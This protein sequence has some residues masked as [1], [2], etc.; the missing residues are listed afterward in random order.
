MP[1]VIVLGPSGSSPGVSTAE[2]PSTQSATL[3]A[4]NPTTPDSESPYIR[5]QGGASEQIALVDVDR[6]VD[7]GDGAE[8]LTSHLHIFKGAAWP[9]GTHTLTISPAIAAWDA[10]TVTYDS[11]PATGTPTIDVVVPAA[12]SAGD[13]LIVDVTDILGLSVSEADT[14]WYGFVLELD[15]TSE[16]TLYSAFAEPDFRPYVSVEEGYPLEEPAD[17]QPSDG[18]VVSQLKPGFT[19]SVNDPRGNEFVTG[20]HFQL[21]T[22]EDFE[23][24]TYDSGEV[25]HDEAYFDGA[26]P[27]GGAAAFSDLTPGTTYY[28]RA[29]VRNTS[30][31]WSGWSDPAEFSVEEKGTL[32]ID[33]PTITAGE[34][35][36]PVPTI[37]VTF[38]PANAESLETLGVEVEV[39]KGNVWDIHYEVPEHIN[40][41]TDFTIPDSD[42]LPY[43]KTLRIRVYGTDD[44]DRESMRG[45]TGY[46]EVFSDEFEVAD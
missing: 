25:S 6:G 32:T 42:A 28:H 43:G 4:D 2:Y 44:I 38:T 45:D 36:S 10:S 8:A 9:A 22:A 13:E 26:S 7:I 11:A 1:I 40:P 19:Y 33:A 29:K 20:I 3:K 17:P 5:L 12:G 30:Q 37:S 24:P 39:R 14:D 35:A 34:I 23:T 27:P 46:I 21:D 18:R 16:A 15:T 31:Q 41:A